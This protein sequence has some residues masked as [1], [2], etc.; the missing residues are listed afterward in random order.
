[1]AG[2]H[3]LRLDKLLIPVKKVNLRKGSFRWP[4]K[5]VLSGSSSADILPLQQ[6]ISVLK[7]YRFKAR[8]ARDS[9]DSAALRIQR[10]KNIKSSEAYRIVVGPE[11]IEVYAG[12]DTGAY[13]AV[14]TLRDL[15]AIHGKS[16]PACQIE[17]EPD[18]VRRGV[19]HDCSRGKVPKLNTLK[20]LV[21]RLA[22]WKI[23][24]LQLYIENVFTFKLHPDIGKGYSP[25][26]PEEILSLQE[27]CQ[28]HHVR[29]VG[30]LASFGHFEKILA[31]PQYCQLGELPGFRNFLGGTT[32]CPGDRRSIKLVDELYSEFVPLFEAKD[33]NVCCDET[34]E[35]GKG[36]SSKRVKR[37]GMAKVYLDFLMKIYRICKKY[38]K[39]MNA[40]ADIV[41]KYPEL[42]KDL[43]RDMVLLNWEYEQDGNK[44][45]RTKEIANTGIPFMVC[46]GTCGWLTHGSRMPNSM[47]NVARFSAQGRKHNAEGM[48]ITDWGD[49]GHRNFLG[50]SLHAFAYG[51]AHA[52][53]GKAVDDKRFTENFCYLTFG[54]STKKM[55]RMMK[56]LGSAYITCGKL[57]RNESLLYHALVEPLLPTKPTE[58]SAIDMMTTKGLQR[59]LSQLSD[60]K[61]WPKPDKSTSRFERLALKE[62]LLAARMDCLASRR[63]LAAKCLRSGTNIRKSELKQL[64]RK[65]SN[66]SEDFKELW[67]LRNKSS[68]LRDNLRLFKQ[69]VQESEK[70][71]EKN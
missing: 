7:Q 66:L 38:G 31:L 6:L 10:D 18:F 13:Y 22:H 41:L 9:L 53:H 25:F 32:L 3:K 56:L 64:S 42:L 37:L 19:Y 5:P 34:W 67:L 61:L 36:R 52:W 58:R 26:T 65:M 8:I 21:E 40:W 2:S 71:A 28:K 60:G 55:A 46:P 70:L 44:I 23:N 62:Y 69:T 1:M 17:D 59:V 11:G 24:E 33:F 45:A 48:L 4:E 39:R 20:E 16:L 51:A 68:C 30:S 29:L 12:T 54:Q 14:Q 47:R 63:T 50:I 15:V 27:Y 49:Q 35:L 57:S 43:P